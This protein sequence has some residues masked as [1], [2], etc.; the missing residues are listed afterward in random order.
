[1]YTSLCP[2]SALPGL[3]A[4]GCALSRTSGDATESPSGIRARIAKGFP[5]PSASSCSSSGAARGIPCGLPGARAGSIAGPGLCWQQC[6]GIYPPLEETTRSIASEQSWASRC[7]SSG[8]EAN[9]PLLYRTTQA[10]FLALF[11]AVF[12][13]VELEWSHVPPFPSV[14]PS[15]VGTNPPPVQWDWQLQTSAQSKNTVKS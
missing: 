14:C 11:L 15:K 6:T 12:L 3:T 10:L 7:D 13:A 5:Q 8:S 1:M 9:T 2:C 4:R